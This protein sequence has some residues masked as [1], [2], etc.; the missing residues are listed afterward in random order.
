MQQVTT[1]SLACTSKIS[2]CL[3]RHR[4]IDL[5]TSVYSFLAQAASVHAVVSRK[6]KSSHFAD[7]SL[8]CFRRLSV[9]VVA[10]SAA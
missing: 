6:L 4:S 3:T 5:T 1:T 7:N 10:V 2:V 9:A 8:T